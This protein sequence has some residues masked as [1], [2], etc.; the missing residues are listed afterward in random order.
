MVR[1]AIAGN[2]AFELSLAEI[3]RGGPSYTA[4][5]LAGL[6]AQRPQADLY[7]IVGVDALLDLPNWKDPQRIIELAR[8]AVAPRGAGGPVRLDDLDRLLPGLAARAV[9]FDMP[10]IGVSATGLRARAARGESIRYLVPE[11]VEAYI[12]EHRLYAEA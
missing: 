9:T 4:D 10:A 7:F 1:L 8:I 12:A 2:D 3:E 11:A 6:R 5:T